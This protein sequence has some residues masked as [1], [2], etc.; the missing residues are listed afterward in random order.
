MG[1]GGGGG[2]IPRGSTKFLKE[3]YHLRVMKPCMCMFT[4]LTVDQI[5]DRRVV[6]KVT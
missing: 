5:Y 2:G 6:E 3:I 1:G 4:L